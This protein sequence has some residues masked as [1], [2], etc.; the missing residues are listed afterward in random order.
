MREMVNLLVALDERFGAEAK[1]R[2]LRG[3]EE[4]GYAPRFVAGADDGRLTAWIDDAF[5][6]TWSEEVHVA[7]AIVA[8]RDGAPAGFAAFAP[9]GLRFAWLRGLGNEPGVG[10]FGPFGV[11]PEHRKSGIGP[12][13]LTLALTG[14]REAGFDRAL[15]PAV[16]E[17]KLVDYYT[18][19]A[20]AH[21]AER[22]DKAALRAK[23]HRAV[24]MASGGGTNFQA[25]LE[26][27]RAGRL[28]V[29]IAAVVCNDAEAGVMRRARDGGVAVRVERWER[30]AEARAAYD[31][32]LLRAV[33]G[34]DA[35]LVLLLGWMHVLDDAFVRTFADRTINLHPA[36]LPLDQTLE[37]VTYPDGSDG[38]AL[39]GAHAI[40]DAVAG[41]AAW[42]GATA[43]EVTLA[44]DRGRVLVRKPLRLPAGATVES[45]TAAIRP[46]ERQVVAGAIT[47]W[48]F[49]R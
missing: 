33:S 12:H 6:G 45:A 9:G 26:A 21:V 15:I 5:G 18:T 3:I 23:V 47:R 30:G 10:I 19:H 38:P 24:V 1:A 34:L 27:S 44:A 22:F 8:Q 35:E 14:L 40:R 46:V 36:Y 43:H 49:E 37:R 48:A 29:E 25:V 17:E 28:P 4:R 7:E 16:G 39:R 32:R 41:G 2:A 20:G 13:L 11:D 42:F 31:A